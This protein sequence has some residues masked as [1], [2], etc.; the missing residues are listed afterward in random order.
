[1]S[2]SIYLYLLEIIG[3]FLIA[4]LAITQ[5]RNRVHVAFLIFASSLGF[6]QL[7]Q[8]LSLIAASSGLQT[9]ATYLLMTSVL[10]SVVMATAVLIFSLSFANKKWRLG[11]LIPAVCVGALAYLSPELA[12]VQITSQA[13]GIPKLD[14]Y[15]GAILL[16]NVALLIISI[17][18]LVRFYRT[19]HLKQQKIQTRIILGGFSIAGTIVILGSFYTS[20]FSDSMAAQFIL[21]TTCLLT[22][23]V[24]LYAIRKAG[25]FDIRLAAVRSVAYVLSLLSLAILYYALVYVV[26]L[27]FLQEHATSS[28]SVSPLNVL[29]ALVL[30]FI[31]QPIKSFFDKITN[32][33]FYRDR[34]QSDVFYAE[35]SELLTTT[36]DLKEMLERAADKIQQTLKT[37]HAFFVIA[38]GRDKYASF[39]AARRNRLP[40]D[41]IHDINVYVERHGEVTIMTS[42][43]E[44]DRHVRRI[45]MSH[46]IEVV[47]PLVRYGAIIGYLMLGE[48]LGSGFTSRDVRVLGTI[49]DELI[50]AIQHALAV[51]EVKSINESLEQRIESA[52][53]ELRTSNARLKRLDTSKD[54]FLS[55]A[56]HQL[57][58]PLTSIKGYLSM[59]LEGDV[60]KVTPMQKKVLEEAFTSSER[61]VHLIHDFLN[62]SRLQTGKFMLELQEVDLVK[63]VSAEVKSLERVAESRSMTLKFTSKVKSIPMTLDDT[64]IRQVVMN[65]I[66]NAIYYSKPDTTIVVDLSK[67]DDSVTLKV[68]D[69]GIGVPA[70]E[71]D[72]LFGKFFRATN[73]RKQRPDG[74]GVGLYLAKKVITALGGEIVFESKIGKG[75]TFGFQ[76]PL[77]QDKEKLQDN[78]KQLVDHPAE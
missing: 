22:L 55:M 21:P 60:G 26:S 4:A 67:T 34:Y 39:G 36:T 8:V 68:T 35:L 59:M 42:L 53:A 13:V 43:I 57:R 6:W 70:N 62:V 37:Q 9:T 1:M 44:D 38:E 51:Q 74:T 58:T 48:Q 11:L 29:L 63:L 64:K 56:S 7:L 17:A 2:I 76:L 50:I 33:I 52:T 20:D 47:M 25:L 3:F 32:K 46:R 71:Q 41:D 18:T 65:Y 45:L 54:E 15:Y 12:A 40:A 5:S 14:I 23:L 19:S 31:F 72:Q 27:V 77:G 61:M 73:A 16:Y 75:S 28:I 69:T 24:F 49:S 10:F 78:T 66:D 30:A